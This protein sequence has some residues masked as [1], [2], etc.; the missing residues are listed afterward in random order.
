MDMSFPVTMSVWIW[1]KWRYFGNWLKI[2]LIMQKTEYF[3]IQMVRNAVSV[4]EDHLV[5]IFPKIRHR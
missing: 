4:L 1:K 5:F 2:S 3:V